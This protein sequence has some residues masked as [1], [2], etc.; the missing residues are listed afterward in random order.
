MQKIVTFIILLALLE[1][2]FAFDRAQIHDS[3]IEFNSTNRDI[4]SKQYYNTSSAADADIVISESVTPAKFR[5]DNSSVANLADGGWVVVFDDNRNGSKKIFWQR[6]DSLGTPQGN[7]ELVASSLIG[8]DMTEPY[9]SADTNGNI[10]LFFRN[11]TEGLIYY[12]KYDADLNIVVP[13]VLVNDTISSSFAGPFSA[14]VYPNGKIVIVWENYSASGSTVVMKSYTNAGILAFGPLTVNSDG[15]SASHW[16]PS[17]DVNPD[18]D[19]LVAWEDYRNN[20]ADIYARLFNGAGAPYGAEFIVIPP[21]ANTADQFAPEVLF[22]GSNQF[23]IAWIDQRSGQEVYGQRY[24]SLS[25]L[26]GTNTILSELNPQIINWNIDLAKSDSE[27]S[28]VWAG[29]GPQNLINRQV[30]ATDLTKVGNQSIINNS[31]SGRRWTPSVSYSDYEKFAVCWS[32]Y[33]LDNADINLN[34]FDISG[35]AILTS[36][37]VAND[38]I[39][40]APSINPQAAVSTDWYTLIAF[41]D[42]RSDVG[43]IYVQAVSNGGIKLYSN[44]KVNQDQASNLQSE[45]AITASKSQLKSFV[46]WVDSRDIAALPGQRIFGRYGSQF[47]LFTEN[48]FLISDTLEVAIK[49]LPKTVMADNGKVLIAWIDKRSGANQIYGQWLDASGN[50]D[51]INFQISNPAN[52]TTFESLQVSADNANRFYVTWLD[53]SQT[54]ADIK[55]QLYLADGTASTKASITHPDNSQQIEKVAIQAN[56]SG[57]LIV[58]FQAFNEYKRIYLGQYASDGIELTTPFEVI[59]QINTNGYD[60]DL[61][62]DNNDYVSICWIDTRNGKPEVY[63]QIYD[64]TLTAVGTNTV[65]ASESVEFMTTPRTTADRGRAWFVWAD[66]RS[67]GFNI[68]ANTRVY[69][70]TDINDPNQPLPKDF[71]LS[72]NYPNPFNPTTEIAFS[73]PYKTKVNLSV[74]N[75]LGQHVKTLTD[76]MYSS[77]QYKVEWDGTNDANQQVA[78]GLYLY[79]IVTDS[80][81]E[82][83]KMLLLK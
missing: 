80:S 28:V 40:G 67:N 9:L 27:I 38:D 51:G 19:I 54:P 21:T 62:I 5:Q 73:I 74:Y 52:D 24:N 70:A 15:G 57:N 63:S 6:Y 65:V 11:Q 39:I 48:E 76:E 41:E 83:K 3:R 42:K 60:V 7:N 66:P 10:F 53:K 81:S 50:K 17:V 78:T 2:G 13:A 8:S 72:Q 16:V 22:T 77:G 33:L 36:E 43:D 1:T 25:G 45:P 23:V 20:R 14:A 32:E 12:S 61:S 29:F 47:G 4:L 30:I 46:A 31:L 64:N 69:E 71:T 49:R 18:G 56:T 37:L 58:V 34:L 55:S 75:M 59:D 79:K 35:T 68:Y 44:I 82:M 26:V